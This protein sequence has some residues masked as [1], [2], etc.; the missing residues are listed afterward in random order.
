MLSI[1]FLLCNNY[2]VKRLLEGAIKLSFFILGIVYV[3]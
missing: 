1:F 2:E 3:I